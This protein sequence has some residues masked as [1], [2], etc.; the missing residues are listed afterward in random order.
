MMVDLP[1]WSLNFS[2]KRLAICKPIFP[3]DSLEQHWPPW[4]LT[5]TG[6][7]FNITDP[8]TNDEVADIIPSM[9]CKSSLL[10][11]ILTS[12]LKR[13]VN[14]FAPIISR[15]TSLSFAK[16]SFPKNLKWGQVT[17]LLK[18]ENLDPATPANYPPISNQST[19]SKIVHRLFLS[20][21]R[22]HV[23]S[24]PGLNTFQSAYRKNHKTETAVIRIL[25]N[26]YKAADNKTPT[27]FWR[28]ICWQR[29]TQS[30]IKCTLVTDW[31][32]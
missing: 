8:T 1:T 31:V 13:C 5:Y 32:V 23:D 2:W 9:P 12:I 27:C 22:A 30:I 14:T 6:T 24:I 3:R 17:P 18:K 11:I 4:C 19:V 25:D 28:W 29:S 21:I 20:R 7:E 26:V 16:G 10:D 15:L